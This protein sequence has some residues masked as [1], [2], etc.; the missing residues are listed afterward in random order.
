MINSYDRFNV[1]SECS[2]APD[3][4]HCAQENE[5][6]LSKNDRPLRQSTT[7]GGS[8]A[9]K[10]HLPNSDVKREHTHAT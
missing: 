7:Q 1:C 3:H 5:N 9:V 4:C 6:G 10:V 8:P 2:G